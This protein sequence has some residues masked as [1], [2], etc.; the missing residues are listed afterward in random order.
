VRNLLICLLLTGCGGVNVQ[1]PKEVMVPVPVPC[2]D[3]LPD[4]PQALSPEAVKA[5]PNEY[6]ATIELYLGYVQ[7][8]DYH[9]QAKAVL[10]A[11]KK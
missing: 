7:L 1:V 2:V 5:I 10:E 4:D 3:K 11:C 9:A 6:Q 8:W